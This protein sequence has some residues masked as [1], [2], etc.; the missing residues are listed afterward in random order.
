MNSLFGLEFII[1]FLSISF[2]VTIIYIE[3]ALGCFSSFKYT[4]F[5]SMLTFKRIISSSI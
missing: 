3:F 2:E 1:Q 5:T 4:H